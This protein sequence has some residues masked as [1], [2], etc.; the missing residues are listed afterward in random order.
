MRREARLLE[1]LGAAPARS[2]W[3]TLR[4]LTTPLAIVCA[5]NLHDSHHIMRYFGGCY[6]TMSNTMNI[7]EALDRYP[8]FVSQRI[9]WRVRII[10]AIGTART[11]LFVRVASESR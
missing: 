8:Q 7:V 9:G 11:C 4:S 5:Q 2:M 3:P 6:R 1:V 10:L